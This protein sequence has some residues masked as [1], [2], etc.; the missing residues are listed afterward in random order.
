MQMVSVILENGHFKQ[1]DVISGDAN[2]LRK[3]ATF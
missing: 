3:D 2:A 1:S